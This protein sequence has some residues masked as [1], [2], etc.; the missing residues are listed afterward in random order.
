MTLVRLTSLVSASN[1]HPELPRDLEEKIE[2][3]RQGVR[4]LEQKTGSVDKAVES[5]ISELHKSCIRSEGYI[6]Q[7]LEERERREDI[8]AKAN[9]DL[10][11]LLKRSEE[12]NISEDVV[13]V[14][15]GVAEALRQALSLDEIDEDS[16]ISK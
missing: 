5:T 7:L 13:K 10:V 12:L 6:R 2:T 3:L 14:I 16:S 8:V 4:E 11:A 1:D 15:S 9:N